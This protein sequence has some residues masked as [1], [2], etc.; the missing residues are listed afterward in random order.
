M[1]GAHGARFCPKG[2]T[3]AKTTASMQGLMAQCVTPIAS[4]GVYI[5][6][7]MRHMKVGACLAY[8]LALW[9]TT[10]AILWGLYAIISGNYTRFYL[11]IHGYLCYFY[12]FLLG[13]MP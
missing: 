7:I 2:G 10:L 6:G 1:G 13:Y 8:V 4:H 12:L 5:I 9:M 3:V 11:A